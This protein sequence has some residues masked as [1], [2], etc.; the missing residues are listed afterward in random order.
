MVMPLLCFRDLLVLVLLLP[1]L[2]LRIALY[3]L[4]STSYPIA[5]RATPSVAE[6]GPPK[7]FA[8]LE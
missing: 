3:I 5:E 8:A 1:K 6:L 7:I 4:C 2:F